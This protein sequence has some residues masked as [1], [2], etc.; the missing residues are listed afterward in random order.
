MLLIARLN[1]VLACGCVP[2]FWKKVYNPTFSC[3]KFAIIKSQ[4]GLNSYKLSV[5]ERTEKTNAIG[6]KAAAVRYGGIYIT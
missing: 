4:A 6:L 3:S 5:T 2:F 1:S